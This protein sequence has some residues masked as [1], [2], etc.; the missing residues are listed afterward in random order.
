MTKMRTKLKYKTK[1][2]KTKMTNTKTKTK[3]ETL[4]LLS[5]VR[6]FTFFF[7]VA[8]L[9]LV[10]FLCFLLFSSPPSGAAGSRFGRGLC[11]L[12]ARPRAPTRRAA[13]RGGGG[14]GRG[15]GDSP[16]LCRC[17][18]GDSDSDSDGTSKQLRREERVRQQ[19]H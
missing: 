12:A 4:G 15:N 17:L 18:R 11:H 5:S 10:P 3:K 7:V 8:D 2:K 19:Q 16:F 9:T 13:N 14:G 1:K 6:S